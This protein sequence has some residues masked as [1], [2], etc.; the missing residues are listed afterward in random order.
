M[1]HNKTVFICEYKSR[2]TYHNQCWNMHRRKK[3]VRFMEQLYLTDNPSSAV[4]QIAVRSAEEQGDVL[5][6]SK[7]V[8]ARDAHFA[9]ENGKRGG[10]STHAHALHPLETSCCNDSSQPLSWYATFTLL[11]AYALGI[12]DALFGC[13]SADEALCLLQAFSTCYLKTSLARPA[14]CHGMAR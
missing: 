13:S 9:I 10:P 3:T 4:E 7:H 1:Q 14:S 8:L 12:Q 6:S 2:D 11:L 5:L